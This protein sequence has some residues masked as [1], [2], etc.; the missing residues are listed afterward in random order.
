M[1]VSM[2]PVL[3]EVPCLFTPK[4]SAL[5]SQRLRD[6]AKSLTK[7]PTT[8]S[9]LTPLAMR[10]MPVLRAFAK[11]PPEIREKVLGIQTHFAEPDSRIACVVTELSRQIH[12]A[13]FY[14]GTGHSDDELHSGGVA[15]SEDDIKRVITSMVVNAADTFP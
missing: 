14:A 12:K 15:L 5:Y 1:G 6:F 13:G 11:A 10:W 3:V 8:D 4:P 7:N 2:E 9:I